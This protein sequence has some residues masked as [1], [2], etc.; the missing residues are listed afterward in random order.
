ML[1][2]YVYGSQAEQNAD[3]IYGIKQNGT[4][5]LSYSY[6]KLARLSSRTLNTTTGFTSNYTYLAGANAGSTTTLIESINNGGNTLSYTYDDVGNITEIKKNN[7]VYE[8]YEYDG[9]NQL[10][11]VTRGTGEDADYYT[12]TYDNGG[13]ILEVKLKN[14]TVKSYDY[15]YAKDDPRESI[16]WKDLLTKYNDTDIE[17]DDIGN[18]LVYRDGFTFEWSNGRQLRRQGDGSAVSFFID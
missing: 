14:T 18:P 12:Y 10:T 9:L 15:D 17:Y 4:D 5:I 6:D 16:G 7:H 13:N 1:S 2:E 3:F 11:K 8:S